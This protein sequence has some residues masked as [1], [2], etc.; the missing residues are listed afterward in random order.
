MAKNGGICLFVIEQ[1]VTFASAFKNVRSYIDMERCQ[2][3]NG[4]DC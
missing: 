3:G 4:A 1:K 2:S